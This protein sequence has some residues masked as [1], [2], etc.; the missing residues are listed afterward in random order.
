MGNFYII[1]KDV[2]APNAEK[3]GIGQGRVGKYWENEGLKTLLRLS[4]VGITGLAL[5][6]LLSAEIVREPNKIETTEQLEQYTLCGSNEWKKNIIYIEHPRAP[7]TLIESNLYKD[8]ILRE[9]VSDVSNYIMDR[10]EL[11]SLVIGIVDDKK[12]DGDAS[13]SAGEIDANAK[14]ECELYKGYMFAIKGTKPVEEKGTYN[15]IS[16]FPDVVVAVEHGADSLENIKEVKIDCESTLGIGKK[17]SAKLGFE[18]SYKFYINY[19][20]ELSR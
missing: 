16:L 19:S 8:Y 5:A 15:W 13:V 9:M 14:Y 11:E 20:R 4:T 2:D 17:L 10:I 1:T 3:R 12:L 6:E 7:K 18:K